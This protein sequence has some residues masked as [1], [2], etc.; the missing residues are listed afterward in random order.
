MQRIIVDTLDFGFIKIKY[1]NGIV[2]EALFVNDHDHYNDETIEQ[3]QMTDKV[4][5]YFTGS[6]KSFNIPFKLQ[7]ICFQK[8]V[9]RE[10]KK[11]PCGETRTYG[12]I[13]E[14]IGQPK[15]FRAVANACG[16][17]KLAIIIPCH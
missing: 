7:G 12:E 16:Q 1:K 8:L 4:N 10:I 5:K 2:H 17:N 15:A 9:W 13:A 14:S 3:E 11:I 6:A